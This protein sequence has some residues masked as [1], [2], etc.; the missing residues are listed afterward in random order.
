[1]AKN[2]KSRI[3]ALEG[4]AKDTDHEYNCTLRWGAGDEVE[5]HYYRDGIEIPRAVY[6]A[7]APIEP[8]TIHWG[9]V[10]NDQGAGDQGKPHES[11][12]E[13]I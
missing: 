12:Q 2:I 8:L 1:M 9:E 7:E 13:A 5:A 4:K 11:P 3:E 6:F 10:T